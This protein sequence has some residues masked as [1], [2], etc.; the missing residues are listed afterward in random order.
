MKSKEPVNLY[1][2]LS[3]VVLILATLGLTGILCVKSRL[4]LD[5]CLCIFIFDF[6]FILIWLF[7]L[8]YDRKQGG[9]SSNPQTNFVRLAAVY[10]GC[11]VLLFL[12]TFL[13][14]FFRPVMVF[15]LL[16]CAV[17][18]P[19]M[20]VSVGLFLDILLALV[21]GGNF[22]A[23]ICYVTLTLLGSVLAQ[24][25][26]EKRYR[27]CLSLLGLF[28]NMMIPDVLYYLCNKEVTKTGL[29]YS[30]G[31]G[32]VTALAEF[33]IFP[34]LWQ[35]S[36]REVDNR[37]L[38]MVS[39]DFSEVKALKDFS[40]AEYHH[41]SYV[42]DL[43]YRC[44][45]R[46]GLRKNVC[47][48]GGFY[49]RMGQWLGEPCVKNGVDKADSLCFPEEVVTILA[50]YYGQEKLPSTPESALVHMVDAL[51]LKLEAMRQD[52]PKSQWN[53]D[54]L[55]YQTLN[56]FSQSGIYDASGMSMNQFL[57]VRE[58]LAKEELLK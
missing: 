37:L 16:I 1:R 3:I 54:I 21:A 49:Y 5:E 27:I 39:E 22:Y 8:E 11:C 45:D 18:N 50:E 48:A 14:E 31:C 2:A 19:L 35:G 4:Y 13:P 28:L 57:K 41:A 52:F 43:A 7:E 29:L 51:L 42:S 6:I 26:V 40:M 58:F 20:G 55:I 56:E 38:D 32:I 47:L 15:P 33:F 46:A 44:A 30:L 9:V 53:S 10:A 12:M 17:S 23:L 25:L 34:W 24:A 36:A